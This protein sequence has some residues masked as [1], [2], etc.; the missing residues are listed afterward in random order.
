M[1]LHK[2]KEKYCSLNHIHQHIVFHTLSQMN[3][4]QKYVDINSIIFEKIVEKR[5]SMNISYVQLYKLL[6]ESMNNT[7]QQPTYDQVMRRKSI[8]SDLLPG[9]CS[10]LN[11][12][13]EEILKEANILAVASVN[14]QDFEW[15]F[16]SLSLQQQSTIQYLA[17]A[18]F[19]A[20]H[21]PEVFEHHNEIFDDY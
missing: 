10:I 2:F 21:C 17:D 18:L 19:M 6:N 5:N 3:N 4:S 15:L 12:S 16:N 9:I 7:V 20:E 11:T 1:N 8:G 13:V 14:C